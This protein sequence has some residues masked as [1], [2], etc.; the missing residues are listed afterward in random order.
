MAVLPF[1]AKK[2][3]YPHSIFTQDILV[4]AESFGEILSQLSG[5]EIFSKCFFCLGPEG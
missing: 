1:E 4:V 3:C 5:V 2:F